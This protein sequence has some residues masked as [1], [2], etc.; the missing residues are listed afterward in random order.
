MASSRRWTNGCKRKC[1]RRKAICKKVGTRRFDSGSDELYSPPP[2]GVR[3]EST[4]ATRRSR[5]RHEYF[6]NSPK[7]PTVAGPSGTPIR[8]SRPLFP[9]R[10]RHDFA[11]F[12]FRSSLLFPFPPDATLVF[13]AMFRR[14]ISRAE[15]RSRSHFG[16]KRSRV[17]TIG[18]ER[19]GR[20]E[21]P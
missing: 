5:G 1:V 17:F 13:E 3:Y 15:N 18:R 8:V 11:G 16:R 14:R 9:F 2:F 10:S 6:L 12:A 20:E 21:N 7:A 4:S 19:A